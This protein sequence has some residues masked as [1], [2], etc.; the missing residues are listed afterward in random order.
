MFRSSLVF[1]LCLVMIA[2]GAH[3]E[4]LAI[5][6]I[7][8]AAAKG[9]ATAKATLLEKAEKGNAEAQFLMGQMYD[10]GSRRDSAKALRWYSKAAGQGNVHAQISIAEMY[11]DARGVKRDYAA[12]MKW[13]SKAAD[14]GYVW[15]P[16]MIGSLYEDGGPG[17]KRDYVEAYFWY[18]LM[19][20]LS[21]DKVAK[22]LIPEQKAAVDKRVEEWKKAHSAPAGP[23]TGK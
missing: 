6:D 1:I 14:Q 12:A 11:R 17:L 20:G 21:T 16:S 18:S 23:L 7:G 9:D 22:H 4:S 19:V 13:Y 2:V 3:A 10:N 8:Y 5:D 15:A